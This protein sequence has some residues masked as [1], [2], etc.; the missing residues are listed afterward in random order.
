MLLW[1]FSPTNVAPNGFSVSLVTI[2]YLPLLVQDKA[3]VRFVQQFFT[4]YLV[5]NSVN[6][7]N[8]YVV[9]KPI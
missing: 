8:R 7:T 5:L 4:V 6:A 1:D 9:N 3:T 2:K